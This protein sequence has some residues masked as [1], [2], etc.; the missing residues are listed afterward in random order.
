MDVKGHA[1]VV[2]GGASGLGRA[3]ARKLVDA[4]TKVALFDRNID[5]AKETAAEFGNGT[6]AVEVDVSS[7]ESAEAAFEQ[8]KAA[9]GPTRVCVNCAGIGGS[10]RIVDRQ[11][12]PMELEHFRRII[13]VNQIGTFNT[14]RLA[15]AQ[16]AA[17]E[18]L[19]EDGIRGVI[20]NTASVAGYEGQ[21]G[22]AAYA[23]SKGGVIGLTIC[24]ARDL[25]SY[26]IRVNTIAPGIMLTPLLKGLPEETLDI[27]GKQVP[28]PKRTG[29]DSEY[30]GMA[31]E[32][33]RNDY[34]NGATVRVDGAIRMGPR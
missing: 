11:G 15:A 2:T 8:A 6:I 33:I 16:M 9:N 14:L 13:E 21:I 34:M 29:H 17:E 28:F 26:G 25:S 20:V 23:S 3:T 30:A 31:M 24:A 7:A 1:A 22:Q 5:L 10:V 27:L 12:K 18:P 4:G 32:L 19:N